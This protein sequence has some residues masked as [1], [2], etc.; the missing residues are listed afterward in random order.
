MAVPHVDL[1]A[2]QMLCHLLRTLAGN[3][4]EGGRRPS[5][6]L[7]VGRDVAHRVQAAEQRAEELLLMGF[8]RRHSGQDPLPPRADSRVIETSQVIDR[9]YDTRQVGERRRAELE[10][11]RHAV[12][13]RNELV[14]PERVQQGGAGDHGA[15]VR[16]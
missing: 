11:L 5:R 9:S 16:A 4:E 10:P 3:G 2:G 1:A 15:N 12:R 14:R 6:R 7:A 8:G 13:R